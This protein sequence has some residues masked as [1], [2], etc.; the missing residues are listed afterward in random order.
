MFPLSF[1]L[2]KLFNKRY[3]WD[4]LSLMRLHCDVAS[5]VMI[6]TAAKSKSNQY[7]GW[8]PRANL[9]I[10][11]VILRSRMESLTREIGSYDESCDLKSVTYAPTVLL[12]MRLFQSIWKIQTLISRLQ[13]FA[14]SYA[15]ATFR[16]LNHDTA[17]STN[18]GRMWCHVA[19][20]NQAEC[21]CL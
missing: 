20:P 5:F 11:A 17:V 4:A 13:D 16:L 14:R 15:E 21:A 3:M 8:W 7:D 9:E 18:Q 2:N 19:L 6:R 10:V 12:R 1:K